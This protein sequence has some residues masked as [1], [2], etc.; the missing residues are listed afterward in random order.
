MSHELMLHFDAALSTDQ[1]N[2]L[3]TQLH[4][5]FGAEAE[6]RDSAKPHLL[7]VSVDPQKASPH[8]V[9]ET[10]KGLGYQAQ[11]VDL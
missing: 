7:F 8:V 10:V 2:A 6:V 3:S 4:E 11:L 5:K 9:L 1:R